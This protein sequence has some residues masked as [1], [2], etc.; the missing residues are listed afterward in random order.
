MNSFAE[1][2]DN[3]KNIWIS[4]TG[5]RTLFVLRL[6]LQKGRTLDELI[7][8]LQ[9]DEIVKKS[10]SKDTVRIVINTLRK[11]GCDIPRPS[12]ASNYKYEIISH[13]FS[14]NLSLKEINSFIKLREILCENFNWKKILLI[15]DLYEKLFLLTNNSEQIDLINGSKLLININK[16]LLVQLSKSELINRKIQIEYNSVKCGLEVL[17]VVP[18]KIIYQNGKLYLECYNFKYS[19]NSILN[20]EKIN[21]II[22]IDMQEEYDDV[23]VYEVIYKLQ[24]ESLKNFELK[25]NE[26][27][28]EKTKNSITVK[29][30]VMNEF[31]F[32]QRILLFACDVEVISP[33]FFKE[34]LVD[35]LKLLKRRYEDA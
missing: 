35:K 13:P 20:I 18:K 12:K 17:D 11:V 32:V 4:T 9:A 34:K 31:L 23:G 22:N 15:N 6:L 19:Q 33:D 8:L 27:I 7:S 14:L 3:K 5:Y 2:L 29:A 30:K 28:I 21:K 25:D 10:I 26:E 16:E 24:N 1:N